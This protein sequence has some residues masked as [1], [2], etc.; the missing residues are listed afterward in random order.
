MNRPRAGLAVADFTSWPAEVRAT[1]NGTSL[2]MGRT[3]AG[4]DVTAVAMS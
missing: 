4:H 2:P 3:S 1:E